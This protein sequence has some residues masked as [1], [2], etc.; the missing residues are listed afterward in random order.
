MN[1][2]QTQGAFQLAH[3]IA[4]LTKDGEDDGNGEAFIMENDDAVDTLHSLI[5]T[6][7]GI[8][9]MTQFHEPADA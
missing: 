4:L 9:G 2:T 6:A 7:R 3:D 8:Y 1:K 5:S